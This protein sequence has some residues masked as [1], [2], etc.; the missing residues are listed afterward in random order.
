MCA[1]LKQR[2]KENQHKTPTSTVEIKDVTTVAVGVLP[3]RPVTRSQTS[4][5]TKQLVPTAL[6]TDWVAQ[7]RLRDQMMREVRQLRNKLEEPTSTPSITPSGDTTPLEWDPKALS[8]HD[9][10]V[11]D[12]QPNHPTE[13]L[14][15]T[16]LSHRVLESIQNHKLQ[17][18]MRD[19]FSLSPSLTKFVRSRLTEVVPQPSRTPTTEELIAATE[20]LI[21][22]TEAIDKHMPVISICIGK[23]IV[24]DVLLDGGSGVNV[25][26]KEERRKLGLPKPSLASFNLKMAN[27]TIA[28]PTGLLRDVMI[29]IHGIPFIVTLTVIDCQ[30]IKS[31][32]SMLLGRPWLRNAKV[33]HDWANDQVQIMGN[34]IVKRVKINRQLGYK[35]VTPHA[36]V[37]YNFAEGITDDEET[38]LLAADPTLQP[39]GTIDWDV[40]SSQL[41]TPAD[42]QTNT[43]DRLFPHSPNTIPVDE[44]PIRDKVKTMDVAY[45]T[46][47]EQ[48]KL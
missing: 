28:K 48:D 13:T 47:N 30:T 19:L 32:Y 20:E 1:Y 7:E 33:I 35:A 27:G 37:C 44:T 22:A 10:M 2:K 36:L 46:H 17:V 41:P 15:T 9:D 38:I 24:D 5:P 43:P 16:E 39:L 26:T 4:P 31:D 3:L 18:T 12:T 23:N 8:Q 25:I 42:D 11:S 14:G 40:L 45:W 34:G 29:H 21:A 6:D